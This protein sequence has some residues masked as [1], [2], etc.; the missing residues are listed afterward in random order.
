MSKKSNKFKLIDLFAGAGG[1][2]NGFEQTGKFEVI[3]AVEINKDAI[4]T[5][6]FNHG[7]NPDIIIKPENS[8]IS[9]ITKIKFRQ[10]L[11]DKNLKGIETVVIG[12]PPCQGFSNANRQK[13]YLISG[14]NQLVKEFARAIN[15]IRPIA[16]LME[17]VKTMNS[18]K[19]KFF[20]TE[21]KENTIYEYSSE[22]HLRDL[23]E[24]T[25]EE[26]FW[27]EDE[28][29]LMEFKN[30]ELKPLIYE[31]FNSNEI[32]AIIS[33]D[34]NLSRIR[35]IIRNLKKLDSYNVT[36][37]SDIRGIEGILQELKEYKSNSTNF[38]K[39]IQPIIDDAIESL[40]ILLARD[41]ID[42][43]QILNKL[44]SL[45]EINQFL[46]YIVELKIEKIVYSNR[47]KIE[48]SSTGKY[49]VSIK[50]K[51]YNIV[52]YLSVF[53]K[54]IGYEIDLNV[55]LASDFY[56]PQNRQRFMILGVNKDNIKNGPVKMPSKI[57]NKGLPFKVIDA[58]GDLE[59]IT[60]TTEVTKNI[61][62]YKPTKITLMQNYFRSNMTEDI[63]YNHINTES[64]PLSKKRFEELNVT[65]GKNFH[66][67]SQELKEVSYTDASRTQN[68][69]YLR[70]NY[71]EPSPTVIN[72]RKSMWQHP[73]KPI[74]LSIREAA[75]LQSFKDDFIFK[76][77][78]DKQYQQIGNAVPPLLA[79]AVAEQMLF[80]LGEE[81]LK[82]LEREF[83]I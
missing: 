66:S 16:F 25:G 15:E 39:Y 62:E 67:L 56:T 41:N 19:H 53:F 11:A 81:P 34:V 30:D 51:S 31:I 38:N 73:K 64:E 40:F 50:V 59:T 65:G 63:I 54:S 18:D 6:V 48:E 32:K 23:V 57:E 36:K 5:Y 29:V 4:E 35:S 14:N 24:S 26:I 79:R 20:V 61:Q 3:G 47:P 22:K 76:G 71:N 43:N 44:T 69:V 17:N 2:S 12:G 68:T 82:R 7:K 70:L 37:P 77:T 42:N 28:I 75:R 9:D 10:F 13:N 1:L 58:I 55:I 45:T 33:T 46:R 80:I 78:K 52:K 21:H 27:L 49:K 74:A 83:N 72:V 60:P 8:N